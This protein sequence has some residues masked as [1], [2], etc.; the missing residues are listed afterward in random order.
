MVAVIMLLL[1]PLLCACVCFCIAR[2]TGKP[3]RSAMLCILGIAGL[4]L[5]AF[6]GRAAAAA[7]K[8]KASRE[9]DMQEVFE[10][11][12]D[13]GT[14]AVKNERTIVKFGDEL[15][16]VIESR[17]E[18]G[19]KFSLG[20]NLDRENSCVI[21]AGYGELIDNLDAN[22]IG[23]RVG[24]VVTIPFVAN[25]ESTGK[26]YL[27]DLQVKIEI[28][29]EEILGEAIP[30]D[31]EVI[32]RLAE[33]DIASAAQETG[34]DEFTVHYHRTDSSKASEVT[35][36]IRHG[37][38]ER[39][40]AANELEF[41]RDG[42][43]FAGWRLYRKDLNY[44]RVLGAAEEGK[45]G[46]KPKIEEAYYIYSD[47][48]D[49][50]GLAHRGAELHLYAQWEDTDEFTVRY[51]ADDDAQAS[52]KITRVTFGKSKK[53]LTLKKL[54]FTKKG[55][56]F[57]GW[58]AYSPKKDTWL[59]VTTEGEKLW[60]SEPSKEQSYR[61]YKDGAY[62]STTVKEGREVHLYAVW[63]DADNR[64][65]YY[66]ADDDAPASAFYTIVA[67]GKRA[68]TLTL[69]K[70]GFDTGGREFLGWRL[71]SEDDDKWLVTDKDGATSWKKAPAK[72]Q[73]YKL[74]KEGAAV[75]WTA[76]DSPTVHLYAQWSGDD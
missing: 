23:R 48:A 4:V 13:S 7:S 74:L 5:C 40:L 63:T 56:R 42:K 52:D 55:K 58:K 14:R 46:E 19:K 59:V 39:I 17:D 30:V 24:E 70:L 8:G 35:S 62:L 61:L 69:E 26:K 51:Y 6:P 12:R 47:G 76:L 27:E 10:T 65:I 29:I 54:G 31:D 22:L 11:F 21:R 73:S 15:R 64:L 32:L 20:V 16:V 36:V 44:W 71:Y 9:Q 1:I 43:M 72:G 57:I 37:S 60:E 25:Y 50:S 45:W 2:K 49:L 33:K 75:S 18:N 53:I 41:W 66:H 68:K 34:K 28:T 38:G 67:D 3:A